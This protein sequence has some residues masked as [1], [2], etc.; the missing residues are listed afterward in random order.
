M[1]ILEFLKRGIIVSRPLGDNSRYDLVLEIMGVLY[2]CQ[3][4][5]TNSST[6][7]LAEFHLTS[8]QAHRGHGRQRYDVD[9]F[10]CVDLVNNYVFIVPNT[11]D[12]GSIKI[13][14]EPTDSGQTSKINMYYDFTLDKFLESMA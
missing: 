13:R 7:K 1:A 12:R 8:S 5:A 2:T 9:L 4:K 3:V 6:P 11:S 10:C 14:Y